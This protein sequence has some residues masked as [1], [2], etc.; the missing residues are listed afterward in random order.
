[1]TTRSLSFQRS[2]IE[3]LIALHSKDVENTII[4]GAK[5]AALTI[6]WIER[7]AEVLRMLDTLRKERPEI[8]GIM[9]EV[10]RV[11]PGSQIADVPKI[12][13]KP[14]PWHDHESEGCGL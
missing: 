4:D 5:Q 1:M 7:Q 13:G 2:C 10:A 6:G 11:F 8:F 14:Y 12:N 3:H 9:C